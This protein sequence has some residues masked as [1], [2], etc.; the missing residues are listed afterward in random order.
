MQHRPGLVVE[1]EPVGTFVLYR[2]DDGE[3]LH[4]HHVFVAPGAQA[5][6]PAAMA[7]QALAVARDVV[8]SAEADVA[9]LAVEARQLRPG[10]RLVVDVRNQQL[11]MRDEHEEDI[12]D[13]GGRRD[14]AEEE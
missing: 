9:V 2:P 12:P 1:G 13:S 4:I 6:D 14:V 5:R 11:I 10:A 7:D 8:G 3:V